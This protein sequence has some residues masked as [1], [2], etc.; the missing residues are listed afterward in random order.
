MLGVWWSGMNPTL[1]CF[2]LQRIFWFI[3]PTIPLTSIPY[4]GPCVE[5]LSS[6]LNCTFLLSWQVSHF[7]PPKI[8]EGLLTFL[9]HEVLPGRQGKS[10][11]LSL[12]LLGLGI[13]YHL[14]STLRGCLGIW[15]RVL[16]WK[17][18]LLPSWS[19]SF[20]FSY[21]HFGSLLTLSIKLH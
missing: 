7:P 16:I 8:P 15:L 12:P 2:L 21:C 4:Q 9:D 13:S 6:W 1:F 20:C 3:L 19:S 5:S 11:L 18:P 17:V 14:L 10:D